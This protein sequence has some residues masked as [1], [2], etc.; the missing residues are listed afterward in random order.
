MVSARTGRY[1]ALS[2][3][4]IGHWAFSA[5]S[6]T[7][8]SKK[9]HRRIQHTAS[10]TQKAST[11]FEQEAAEVAEVEFSTTD[12]IPGS[13]DPKIGRVLDHSIGLRKNSKALAGR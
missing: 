13:C 11:V 12:Q 4:S 8:C 9:S 5:A 2:I 6:A 3:G 10:R 1:L 7:S